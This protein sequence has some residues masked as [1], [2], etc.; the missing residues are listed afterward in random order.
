MSTSVNV[1]VGVCGVI[2][3]TKCV[4]GWVFVGVYS[5]I[6]CTK[7]VGLCLCLWCTCD[8]RTDVDRFS[9]GTLGKTSACMISGHSP[10]K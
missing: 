9:G 1:S 6:V 3:C 10:L 5:T 7:C 4:G 8:V 2:V